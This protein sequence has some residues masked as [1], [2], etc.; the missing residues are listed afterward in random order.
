VNHEVERPPYFVFV[1]AFVPLVVAFDLLVVSF[2]LL[3]VIPEWDLQLLLPL[4]VFG[5]TSPKQIKTCQAPTPRKPAP[6]LQIR[7]AY[8]LCPA[9]YNEDTTRKSPGNNPGLTF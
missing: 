7:V 4:S 1:V 6:T 9:S 5:V 3:V 2:D 8:E